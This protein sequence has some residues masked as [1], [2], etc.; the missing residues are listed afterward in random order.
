MIRRVGIPSRFHCFGA[1][2]RTEIFE[3]LNP[4]TRGKRWGD[5]TLNFHRRKGVDFCRDWSVTVRR[6]EI[7]TMVTAARTMPIFV[8]KSAR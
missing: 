2:P 3:L 5:W 4:E 8:V 7:R 6:A 1:R